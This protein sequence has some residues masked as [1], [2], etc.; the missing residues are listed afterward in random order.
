[1]PA[2]GASRA[3][4]ITRRAAETKGNV[5]SAISALLARSSDAG[6]C[7]TGC[8]RS[9]EVSPGLIAD[10]KRATPDRR[11]ALLLQ[12]GQHFRV[13]AGIRTHDN[14]LGLQLQSPLLT[15]RAW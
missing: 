2:D 3:L 9:S 5:S 14:L 7:N 1:M 13:L 12:L 10:L 8:V 6:A 4:S 15:I 11:Q